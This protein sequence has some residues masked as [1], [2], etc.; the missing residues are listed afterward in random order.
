M[1]DHIP[2]FISSSLIH[3]LLQSSA[4][5]EF[6]LVHWVGVVVRSLCYGIYLHAYASIGAPTILGNCIH[7]HLRLSHLRPFYFYFSFPCSIRGISLL[8]SIVAGNKIN[9]VWPLGHPLRLLKT[10]TST[11]VWVSFFNL[12]LW[13][14]CD[15]CWSLFVFEVHFY[16]V[17]KRFFAT[18]YYLCF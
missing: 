1:K 9:P 10:K 13:W 12:S 16:G 2:L 18:Y 6:S 11:F 3:D 15:V 17:W 5:N 14:I 4:S 7:L 8:L